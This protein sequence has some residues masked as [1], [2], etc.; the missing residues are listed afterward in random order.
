MDTDAVGVKWED[1]TKLDQMLGLLRSRDYVIFRIPGCAN[2]AD[3][4]VQFKDH[5]PLDPP[6]SGAINWNALADSLW[7]GIDL[8]SQDRVAIVWDNASLLKAD[9][10]ESIEIA[11]DIFSSIST[12]LEA[13]KYGARNKKQVVFILT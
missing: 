2:L 10:P 3:Q 11:L 4:F 6:L 12:D 9:S 5:L 13:A 7:A 1:T 8:L